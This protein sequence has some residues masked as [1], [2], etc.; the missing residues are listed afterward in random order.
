MSC[1]LV[2]CGAGI[3]KIFNK[4]TKMREKNGEYRD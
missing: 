2:A 3:K 4:D 1:N